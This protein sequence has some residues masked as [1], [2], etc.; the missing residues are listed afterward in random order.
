MVLVI[1]SRGYQPHRRVTLPMPLVHT[2]RCEARIGNA[3]NVKY[4]CTCQRGLRRGH[5]GML[6]ITR[7]GGSHVLQTKSIL[8]LLTHLLSRSCPRTRIGKE[9][10]RR[11]SSHGT[12]FQAA[13]GRH[14][15]QFPRH[16]GHSSLCWVC[17]N[18][19]SAGFRRWPSLAD[20]KHIA[21]VLRGVEERN[22]KNIKFFLVKKKHATGCSTTKNS[23]TKDTKLAT[24]Y[25]GAR[26]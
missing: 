2:V 22:I 26:A 5:A 1:R 10:S 25:G 8:R 7:G 11:K 17:S 16:M 18:M 19:C 9:D 15:G 20:V 3:S 21:L 24:W 14:M 6:I 13:A 23:R 12:T 4:L